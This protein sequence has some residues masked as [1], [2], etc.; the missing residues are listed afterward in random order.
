VGEDRIGELA[1]EKGEVGLWASGSEG[2][3]GS[4]SGAGAG[5][6]KKREERRP[7][8]ANVER[9]GD[10]TEGWGPPGFVLK[11]RVRGNKNLL[12]RE[13][14]CDRGGLLSI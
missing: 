11:H 6:G 5:A 3:E 10:D 9:E 8:G 4:L 2:E 12:Q 1:G 14:N 13:D 7:L